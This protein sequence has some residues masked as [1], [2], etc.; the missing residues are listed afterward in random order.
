MLKGGLQKDYVYI[1]LLMKLGNF[2]SHQAAM[3]KS[4]VSLWASY[5][6]DA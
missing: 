3:A 5:V 6:C 2:L 4:H 1:Y